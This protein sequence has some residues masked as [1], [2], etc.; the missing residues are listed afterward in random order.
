L[1]PRD[2]N[3]LLIHV[4]S[5]VILIDGETLAGALAHLDELA[6]ARLVG[7]L[8]LDLD[9]LIRVHYRDRLGGDQI[10]VIFL[11]LLLDTVDVQGTYP[12]LL[13][14]VPQVLW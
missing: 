7:H 2:D 13:L 1:L 6:V 8:L 12:F 9:G 14:G 3:C 5:G 10:L 11:L 4:L